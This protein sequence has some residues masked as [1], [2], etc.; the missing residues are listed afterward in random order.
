L[1]LMTEKMTNS[2]RKKYRSVT[3]QGEA[4]AALVPGP[5]TEETESYSFSN[6]A[7]RSGR[8]RDY[9][10]HVR[11]GDRA[12]SVAFPFKMAAQQRWRNFTNLRSHPARKRE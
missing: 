11:K 5:S 4:S 6:G 1:S 3:V 8:Q 7:G 2:G 12:P 9:F 10:K